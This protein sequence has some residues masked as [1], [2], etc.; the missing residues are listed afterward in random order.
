MK[1]NAE[2]MKLAADLFKANVEKYNDSLTQTCD[3]ITDMLKGA[4][5]FLLYVAES[6]SAIK[7]AA[8]PVQQS[9]ITL[10]NYLDQIEQATKQLHEEIA[11]Q[12]TTLTEAN[13][14][15][16]DNVNRLIEGMNEYEKNIEHAWE[17]YESNFNRVGGE[18]EKATDIVTDRLQ[19]YNEMMNFGMTKALHDFDESVRNAIGSLQSLV[20][21]MQDSLNDLQEKRRLD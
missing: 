16:G 3:K 21:D 14:Q 2:Q 18:L 8:E 17:N 20:D 10:K 11:V 6:T 19:K 7:D 1:E 4:E 12:L 15:S 13:R 5:D 9:A